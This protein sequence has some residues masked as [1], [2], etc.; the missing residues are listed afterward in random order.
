MKIEP[1]YQF[2]RDIDIIKLTCLFFINNW[3]YFFNQMS[4]HFEKKPIAFIYRSYV[5]Y[6]HLTVFL[7]NKLIC[8][9]HNLNKKSQKILDT[10]FGNQ[11]LPLGW[12]SQ[13]SWNWLCA[14]QMKYS[15]IKGWLPDSYLS[16]EAISLW[17][18]C[19]F[20]TNVSYWFCFDESIHVLLEL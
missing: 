13:W 2:I 14:F 6:C 10:L 3:N 16:W 7:P 4:R 18:N 1:S 11:S 9:I 8:W 20:C 17:I 12:L 15:F 19:M 5:Y